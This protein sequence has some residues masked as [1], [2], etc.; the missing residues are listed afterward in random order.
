MLGLLDLSY[1]LLEWI[2]ASFFQ[3]CSDKWLSSSAYT[4]LSLQTLPYVQPPVIAAPSNNSCH[5]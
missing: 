1:Y 3:I 4:R 2:L 5:V